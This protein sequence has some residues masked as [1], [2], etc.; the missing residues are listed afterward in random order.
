MKKIAIAALAALILA[1]GISAKKT[2][3]SEPEYGNQTTTVKHPDWV[4]NAVI[5][6][7]N[8]RQGS[9]ERNLKGMQLQ[10]PRLKDLG[11]DILWLM[12][13]HPISEKN[14]KGELGSY[15]AVQDYLKVNPEFGTMQDLQE[16]VRTAHSLGMKVIIDEVCNHTGCDNPWLT[17]NPE[18]YARDKKGDLI[19]PF[20]WTDTY[21][22]DYSNPN[23]RRAMKDAL[24]FWVKEADID[25]YRCDVAGEVPTDFWDEARKE[26]NEVKPVFMLAE[27]SKPE[28]TLNAF[29]ADYN[30]PMKDVFNAIS[31]TQGANQY[32]KDKGQNLPK[33]DAT[34]IIKLLD[35][36]SKQYPKGAINM[37]MVTNHDLNSWEGTEFERFGPALG[38]FATLSYTLPGMPMMYTGQEVGYNHAFEFFKLDSVP[39]YTANEVTAFY[40]MLNALKHT[41]SALDAAN[42]E[43]VF[44]S[45]PTDNANVIAFTRV[46][47]EDKVYVIANLGAQEATSNIAGQFPELDSMKNYMTGAPAELPTTLKPWEYFI[48]VPQ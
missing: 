14:R 23:L 17:T 34:D 46:S 38:A 3:N 37:N 7:I 18:Y 47:P 1:P 11:V 27:S 43:S 19:S 42:E 6:E 29:D 8:L 21:K 30:W 40:E 12:P 31:A 25:G 20:D 15:Y 22:L 41:H 28:L 32:A 48:F 24:L 39:D 44:T 35:K 16:F 5:Y 4:N 45:L 13:I 26:L 33:K 2:K 36:Q 10:L 9:P